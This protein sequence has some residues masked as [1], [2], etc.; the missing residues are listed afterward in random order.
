MEEFAIS[1]NLVTG[2]S[3]LVSDASATVTPIYVTRKLAVA[4][5]VVTGQ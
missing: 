4:S 1:V 3:H 5:T 2:T